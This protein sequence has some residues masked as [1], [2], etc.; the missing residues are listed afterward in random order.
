[1]TVGAFGSMSERQI[2]VEM[3]K[4]LRDD[5]DSRQACAR[6]I[7]G[8]LGYHVNT[9]LGWLRAEFGGIRRVAEGELDETV[10][11]LHQK[12]RQLQAEKASLLRRCAERK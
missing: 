8:Q 4:E 5:F 6:V 1:M 11:D 9:V 3:Y 2:A 7:A 10:R 12:V